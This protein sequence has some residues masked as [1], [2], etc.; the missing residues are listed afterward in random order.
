MIFRCTLWLLTLCTEQKP[1]YQEHRVLVNLCQ[2]L[3]ASGWSECWTD[4]AESLPPFSLKWLSDFPS[5]SI[6]TK[7]LISNNISSFLISL[8]I[9]IEVTSRPFQIKDPS[10]SIPSLG[11]YVILI[12]WLHWMRGLS[13]HI[14]DFSLFNPFFCILFLVLLRIFVC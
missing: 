12:L 8:F 1:E 6:P 2:L 10:C 9:L 13:V 11:V 4:S 14:C 7:L 5:P 3:Q